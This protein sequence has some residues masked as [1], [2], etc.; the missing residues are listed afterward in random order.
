MVLRTNFRYLSAPEV[1]F[2][3]RQ[4]HTRSHI[5][6]C[7]QTSKF[8]RQPWTIPQRQG[9]EQAFARSHQRRCLP[10]PPLQ[11]PTPAGGARNPEDRAAPKQQPPAPRSRA[12]HRSGSV[13]PAWRPVPRREAQLQYQHSGDRCRKLAAADG[14]DRPPSAPV[15]AARAGPAAADPTN[16]RAG[17]PMRG[18]GCQESRQPSIR[19]GAQLAPGRSCDW[20]GTC[21]VGETGRR[22]RHDPD[23]GESA[24]YSGLCFWISSQSH[25]PPCRAI[26]VSDR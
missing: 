25:V 3:V 18:P 26:P 15:S 22:D 23:L 11:P 9:S 17:W 4:E 6:P 2:S 12:G 20:G 10:T 24:C 13:V 5:L 8:K 16:R 19:V 7:P 14:R 21:Y 1:R